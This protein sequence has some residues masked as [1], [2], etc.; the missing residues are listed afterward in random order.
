MPFRNPQAQATAKPITTLHPQILAVNHQI[1]HET[2]RILK[3][4]NKWIFV[5]MS[6]PKTP[7]PY[8]VD[9]VSLPVVSR[10]I[11]ASVGLLVSGSHDS[12]E[13]AGNLMMLFA[14]CDMRPGDTGDEAISESYKC[15]NLSPADG[16]SVYFFSLEP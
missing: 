12:G 7:R 1:H 9:T 15:M 16:S 11:L 14:A 10:S 5:C 2:H 3:E 13:I 8:I 4:E 6:M